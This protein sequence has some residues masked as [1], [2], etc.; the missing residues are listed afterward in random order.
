MRKYLVLLGEMIQMRPSYACFLWP[1]VFS[2]SLFPCDLCL[3]F[4]DLPAPW[5]VRAAVSVH[6]FG[7]TSMVN[8]LSSL[9]LCL[10]HLCNFARTPVVFIVTMS[11]LATLSLS[12][13]AT[14]PTSLAGRC[15]HRHSGSVSHRHQSSLTVTPVV[16]VTL[17]LSSLAC[18]SSSPSLW[19]YQRP[20]TP[21]HSHCYNRHFDSISRRLQ[22]ISL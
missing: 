2:G 12:A 18:P 11:L 6:T 22:P 1:L 14:R 10:S 5:S 20:A 3:L 4:V 19:L 13:I 7:S 8:T 15:H 21:R 9:S 16:T 17:S